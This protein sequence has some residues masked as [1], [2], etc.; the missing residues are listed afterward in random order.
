MLRDLIKDETGVTSIQYGLLVTLIGVVL[1]GVLL[2]ISGSIEGAY[3][4]IVGQL[5]Q[6]AGG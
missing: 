3:D 5:E 4:T 2:I 1:V 6:V